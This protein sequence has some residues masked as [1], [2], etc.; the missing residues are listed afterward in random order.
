MLY[1]LVNA[2]VVAD[3]VQSAMISVLKLFLSQTDPTG[4]G[5][6]G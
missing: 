5:F 6:R 3:P 4:L 2:M 1:E